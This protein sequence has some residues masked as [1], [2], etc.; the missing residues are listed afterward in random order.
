M[1]RRL[2]ASFG[3]KEKIKFATGFTLI[4]ALVVLFIFSLI[5]T[6]FYSIFSSGTSLIIE[7]KNKLKATS[8]ANEKMEIIRSLDY[9]QVGIVDSGYIDG[10]IPSF[11]EKNLSGKTF[12]IFSSVSYV[13]N[14][15]DGSEGEDPDD[16]RPADFKRVAIKVA[17]ENDIN[18]KK[19]V[20]F[21]SDFAPPGVEENISGGT[22]VIKVL[23]R[24]SEGI[25]GASVNVSNSALGINENFITNSNGGVSL[26]GIPADG[27]D[28][29]IS[30][31]KTDYFSIST[32]PPYPDST[33]NPVYEHASI[34]D[35]EKNI[36]SIVT[37]R[38]SDLT[39]QTKDS[40]G[41]TVQGIAYNLTGG[42]IKSNSID[43]P[44]V[45]NYYYSEN[46]NSGSGGENKIEDLGY[47]NYV[48]SFSDP[49]SNYEFI[50]VLPFDAPLNDKAKFNIE[51]GTSVEEKAIFA[52]KNINSLLV[53][54]LDSTNFLPIKNASV[55]LHNLSLSEP[56]D[57]TL[58]TDDFGLAFFPVSL[59]EL[60]SETYS[61][62]AKASGYQDKNESVV[63]NKYT[64]SELKMDAE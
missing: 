12:F 60:I 18:T 43:S 58:M 14:P 30:V 13:D 52:D 40:F 9:S 2:H 47:G 39:L 28:Y 11:E 46:L 1:I 42:I 5:A 37:D 32:L 4:E 25:A 19:A 55:R 20:F 29:Q 10:D 34:T 26:P 21:A 49:S 17:W 38:T 56:Y 61:M 45:P 35:G 64:K 41:N 27:K 62:E 23:N 50:K 16:D 22:L 59:P 57:V 48:F 7:A 24:D 8:L 63:I 3:K 15:Y 44:P 31:S 54:V 36:Y 33:F 53:T 51:P 6:T